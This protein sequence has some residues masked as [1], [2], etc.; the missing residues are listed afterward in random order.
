[1]AYGLSEIIVLRYVCTQQKQR[2]GLE[3]FRFQQIG[4]YK[5]L[6]TMNGDRGIQYGVSVR[7]E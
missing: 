6:G 5:N 7:K 3:D 1:M 2:R 4:F